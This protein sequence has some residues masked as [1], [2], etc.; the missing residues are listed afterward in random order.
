[1][2]VSASRKVARYVQLRWRLA[3]RRST[4]DRLQA[5]GEAAAQA[6]ARLQAEVAG[7]EAALTGGQRAEAERL[8][9]QHVTA[10]SLWEARQAGWTA[11][12]RP[13]GGRTSA[14]T[15]GAR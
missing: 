11:G 13:G 6:V 3:Q 5:L 9:R 12:E 8:L 4:V 7:A 10:R 2:R 15:E 1:M 14:G